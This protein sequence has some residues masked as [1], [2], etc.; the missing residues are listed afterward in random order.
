MYKQVEKKFD[1][2]VAKNAIQF[3][4]SKQEITKLENGVPVVYTVAESLQKKPE[5]SKADEPKES[6][7]KKIDEDLL[8]KTLDDHSIVLNKF[9]VTKNHV[10]VVTNEVE[11]QSA[12]LSEE[13]WA[14]AIELLH[15]L[16]SESGRR[17]VGF[18]NS[19]SESGASVDHKHIQFIPLP[20][21]F[22]PFPDSTKE[23]DD[24]K[25]YSD[26]RV[27]FSN[28]I[29]N[30]P[31]DADN[32]DVVFRYSQILSEVLTKTFK[33]DFKASNKDI[34]YNIVF[35]EDWIVGVPRKAAKSEG[36]VSINAL[37]TIGMFLAKSEEQLKEI[38]DKNFDLV[39]EAGHPFEK[40][41]WH[42][43]DFN[44]YTLY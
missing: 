10:L 13:D 39:K 29:R 6:P 4:E 18:Y 36:G 24:D 27:P 22:K 40:L 30:V 41:E 32:D 21:G 7:W 5:A 43:P 33:D 9:P 38:K 15:A 42:A 23:K 19:G 28:Y 20:E 3:A 44:G 12:P 35:S 11:P 16:N 37:A 8:V 14:V 1:D 25:V 17:Y 34:H 26:N 31:A 2:A